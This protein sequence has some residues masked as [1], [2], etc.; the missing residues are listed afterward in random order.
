MLPDH[1]RR[2]AHSIP[3]SLSVVRAEY[4]SVS[5]GVSVRPP[6]LPE[7]GSRDPRAGVCITSA[8]GSIWVFGERILTHML[9]VVD[10]IAVHRIEPREVRG[11]EAGSIEHYLGALAMLATP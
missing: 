3:A 7:Q 4:R 1:S 6:L 9:A 5:T 8:G 2:A 10:H 11:S